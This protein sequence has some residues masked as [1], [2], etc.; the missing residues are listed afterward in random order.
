MELLII[1]EVILVLVEIVDQL[2]QGVPVAPVDHTLPLLVTLVLQLAQT[3]L[4]DQATPVAQAAPAAP[5]AL[6]DL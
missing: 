1:E 5:V 3:A 4:V 6:V 2:A